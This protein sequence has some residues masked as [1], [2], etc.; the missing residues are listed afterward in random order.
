MRVAA[1]TIRIS[2]ER[3]APAVARIAELD[4]ARAPAAPLLLAEVDGEPRAA[5]SLTDGAVVA[6]P[7]HATAELV[8]L[9]RARRLQLRAPAPA[10]RLP[11]VRRAL[12]AALG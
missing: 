5:I 6:N 2:L 1:V 8:E 7:F 9:L 3:D 11:R 12:A 10:R 4:S